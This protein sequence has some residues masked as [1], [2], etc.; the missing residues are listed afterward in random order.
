[1]KTPRCMKGLKWKLSALLHAGF[2]GTGAAVIRKSDQG[3]EG[4][5]LEKI[6][7]MPLEKRCVRTPPL[8]FACFAHLC[9]ICDWKSWSISGLLHQIT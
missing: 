2:M 3:L 7:G 5:I 8:S 9:L 6:N 4:L 1:M